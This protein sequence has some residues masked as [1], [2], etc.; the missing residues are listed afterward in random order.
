MSLFREYVTSTAFKLSLSKVQIECI[1]QID[2]LGHS[3]MMLTTFNALAG[4][5][6]VERRAAGDGESEHPAGVHVRLTEAGRAVIPL[7][8][9]AGLYLELP[10]WDPPVDLP[11]IDVVIRRKGEIA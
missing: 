6:L 10:K 7:L 5:G 1:C 9:L 3:W 11:P 4:K 2:Q 8:K